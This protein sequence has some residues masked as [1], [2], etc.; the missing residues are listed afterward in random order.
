LLER[1]FESRLTTTSTAVVTTQFY[2]SQY[3][4]LFFAPIA[5]AA[6]G[7]H[8]A[9]TTAAATTPPDQRISHG[10]EVAIDHVDQ[11]GTTA[12]YQ[13]V[14]PSVPGIQ[15]VF[16]AVIFQSPKILYQSLNIPSAAPTSVTAAV[17]ANISEFCQPEVLETRRV[18]TIIRTVCTKIVNSHVST[19]KS[20]MMTLFG[21]GEADDDGDDG[22]DDATTSDDDDGVSS[23]SCGG[24]VAVG[25]NQKSSILLKKWTTTQGWFKSQ[26]VNYD[27]EVLKTIFLPS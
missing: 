13:N 8:H 12:L 23:R 3:K 6:Q 27:L 16:D 24:A 2:K 11:N 14:S 26:R 7:Y 25:V 15:Q 18:E 5:A 4:Q 22:D 21:G 17:V 9:I 20:K 19:I 10:I 1:S